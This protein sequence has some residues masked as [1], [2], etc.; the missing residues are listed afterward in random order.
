MV[1]MLYTRGVHR[2]LRFLP[3]HLLVGV[4]VV[5]ATLLLRGAGACLHAHRTVVPELRRVFHGLGSHVLEALLHAVGEVRNHL[6]HRSLVLHGAAHALRHLEVAALAEVASVGALR[7]GVEGT[8]AAVLLHAHA[9]VVEVLTRGLG[10]TREHGAA[11]RDGGSEGER[12][13]DVARVLDA[14]VGDDGNAKLRREVGAL[15]DGGRLAA[16]HRAHLLRGADGAGTHADAESVGASLEEPLRLELGHDVTAD[17]VEL[18]DVR[19]E[20]LDHLNLVHGVALG[21]VEDDHV[22]TLRGESLGALLVRRAGADRGAAEEAALLVERGRAGGREELLRLD[23]RAGHQAH[24]L[25]L[26]VDHRE[27]T[28]LGL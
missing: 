4:H 14:A 25:A 5:H 10:G 16:A 6:H 22:H 20:P 2:A 19:L 21:G 17:D 18:G 9:V 24:E 15:V 23:R 8:H 7:H 13:G 12:L 11:H 28:L 27:L 26:V 1:F 3:G